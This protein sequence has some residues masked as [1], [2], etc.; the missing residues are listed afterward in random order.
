[1][2]VSLIFTS[3]CAE[4]TVALEQGQQS[5]VARVIGDASSLNVQT[6]R[7]TG[8][9]DENGDGELETDEIDGTTII[10]NGTNGTDGS[11]GAD[12]TDALA[13][14]VSIST[15]EAGDVCPNGGVAISHGLDVN[16]NGVLDADEIEE[17]ETVCHGVSGDW[18][19]GESDYRTCST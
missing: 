11:D 7:G 14:R 10:C 18:N 4:E 3:A 9:G 2:L 1:M 15:V 8:Y 16:E 6:G 19:T 5:S 17:T 13:D 12:G